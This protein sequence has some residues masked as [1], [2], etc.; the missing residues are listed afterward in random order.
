MTITWVKLDD[1]NMPDENE[2]VLVTFEA[3]YGQGINVGQ[4]DENGNWF[5]SCEQDGSLEIMDEDMVIKE[6]AYFNK[7]AGFE[8]YNDSE[9]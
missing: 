1:A 9:E 8:S 4:M 7:P 2:M 3:H 6:W 5:I